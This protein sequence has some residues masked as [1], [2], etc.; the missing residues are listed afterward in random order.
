MGKWRMTAVLTLVGVGLVAG[1]A[2]AAFCL[3]PR[4]RVDG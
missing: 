1:V 3:A 4:F 2:Y